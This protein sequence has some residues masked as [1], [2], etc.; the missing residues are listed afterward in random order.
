MIRK[1]QQAVLDTLS[2]SRLSSDEE[3]LR[4][5][6]DFFNRR[7]DS[8][9]HTLQN[10]AY[11]EDVEGGTAYFVVKN[12][13][14]RIVFF[15]SLKGGLLYDQ[16]IDERNLKFMKKISEF[17]EKSLNDPDITDEQVVLFVKFLEK[18][19]SHKGVTKSDLENLP[20]KD[21]TLLDDLEMELNNNITHVGKTYSAVEL[22]HFCA[23]DAYR[24]NWSLDMM[25]HTLG[26]VVYW[27]FVVPKVIEARRLMGVQ[28][29]YLFAADMSPDRDLVRYYNARLKFTLDVDRSTVKPLYDLS[30]KFMYQETKDLERLQRL[31]FENFSA[32]E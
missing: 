14:G 13:E 12:G 29:F 16:H 11:E 6:D 7:N 31:F 25:E 9:S 23:N 4:L 21:S 19:R 32:T 17:V 2:C 28:Y 5:V 30:C 1:E 15:F 18:L 20:Q 3:H 10:E 24:D 26:E 22:V 27:K 8:L